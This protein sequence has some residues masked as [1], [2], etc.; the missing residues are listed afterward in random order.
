MAIWTGKSQVIT[1]TMNY[2]PL[3]IDEYNPDLEILLDDKYVHMRT[4]SN[5]FVPGIGKKLYSPSTSSS[6]EVNRR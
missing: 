4:K 5:S 1:K 3:Y 6:R 2:S